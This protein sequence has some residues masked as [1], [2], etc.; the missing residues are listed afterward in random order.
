MKDEAPQAYKDLSQ[1]MKNQ[2]S[3]TDIE[4]R[5][6]PL[7]NVKGYE[8]IIPKKYRTKEQQLQSLEEERIQI[9]KGIKKTAQRLEQSKSSERAEQYK[10]KLAKLEERLVK[11][12]VELEVLSK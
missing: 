11:V 7:V 4:H 2:E 10:A 8:E 1:V 12:D 5:L 9:L 3:L 6:L